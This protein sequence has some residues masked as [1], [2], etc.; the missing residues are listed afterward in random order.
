MPSLD[1]V[2]GQHAMLRIFL[3]FLCTVVTASASET[4]PDATGLHDFDFQVGEWR[5]HHRILRPGGKDEWIEME[6]TCVVRPLASNSMNVE[7]H[8]FFRASGK[9]YAVGLRAYDPQSAMWAIW[10]VDGRAPHSPLD[11][12]VKGKFEKGIGTFTNDY[13]ENGKPMRVRYVWSQIT[14]NSARWEQAQSADAGATW[15]TNW[16]MEFHRKRSA[17]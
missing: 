14:A 8:Q 2:E 17:E 5:V 15:Q 11:P 3:L 1:R 12:P 7:E 4:T 10:W 6:G 16:I 9:T 13:M